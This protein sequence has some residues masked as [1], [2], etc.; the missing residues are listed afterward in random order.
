[1]SLI[2]KMLQDLDARG[3]KSGPALQG[4]IKPVLVAD[5]GAAR[6]KIAYVV[7]VVVAGIGIG[8]LLWMKRQALTPAPGDPSL[9]TLGPAP[10]E[11]ATPIAPGVLLPQPVAVPAPVPVATPAPV[12]A[13]VPAPAPVAAS[14]AFAAAPTPAPATVAVRSAPAR[15]A[16]AV[17]SAPPRRADVVRMSDPQGEP[18]ADTPAA[19]VTIR[20]AAATPQPLVSAGRQMTPV[21]QSESQYR[22][23]LQALD[24]G[25]VSAA[26]VHLEQALKLNA[27]HEAARQ[28]LVG[29]LL[30]AGRK[31]EAVQQL[32]QG[33][34]AW[35]GQPALAMLLARIQIE[36]GG[37]GV[38]T[39][40]RSLA[41]GQG[42]GDYHAFLAGALQRDG[43]HRE[44]VEQYVQALRT[45]PDNSVWLM[46]LGISLEAEK[47]NAEALAAF[48]RAASSATLSPPLQSF[49]DKKA[50]ALRV[51]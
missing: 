42:S 51:R 50:D 17:A 12:P 5:S 34:A 9:A 47:R 48:Q 1:M 27:R 33:L 35:S 26:T 39:L 43:R 24:E 21:Q 18:A 36:R 11:V 46:G 40:Q 15:R 8:T 28:S 31:D 13:P 49:V 30:E 25:R 16:P 19:A 32:E 38:A 45:A 44:A 23:A 10:V 41:A 7:I 22:Q 2:N 37:S 6:R 14:P 20:S 29:L 4:E 3:Q